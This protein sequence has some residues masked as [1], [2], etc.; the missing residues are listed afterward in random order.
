[1]V[2]CQIPTT[3]RRF[4]RISSEMEKLEEVKDIFILDRGPLYDMP[5]ASPGSSV[6]SSEVAQ[7][8]II[9]GRILPESEP[10]CQRSFRIRFTL[11]PDYPFSPPVL[12]CLDPMYHPIINT[13]GKICSRLLNENHGY[14]ITVSL[15][16]IIKDVAQTLISFDGELAINV[17]AYI[18]YQNDRD[19][20]D[21]KALDFTL[22]YGY[23]RT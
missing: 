15:S 18:E 7:N 11:L 12:R 17:K 2:E 22:R 23:P 10:Y 21:R 13:N 19:E 16:N 20:F 6:A 9:E 4:K 3:E 1:M 14:S 5:L 8:I